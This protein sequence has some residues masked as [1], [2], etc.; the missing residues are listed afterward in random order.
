MKFD[1]HHKVILD[2]LNKD[3][4][5]DFLDFLWDELWRHQDC[6]VSAERGKAL[7]PRIAP[8]Y[9]SAITRHKENVKDIT[10]LI[11]RVK[12]QFEIL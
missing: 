10:R 7:R 4:A 5:R 11:K 6:I 9:A 8:V 1:T 2:T 3:E 12:E